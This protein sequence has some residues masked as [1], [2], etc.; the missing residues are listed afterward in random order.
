MYYPIWIELK[1][2]LWKGL[3]K[4]RAKEV[5]AKEEKKVLTQ[6]IDFTKYK[7]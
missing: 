6:V 4:R 3:K 5:P 7:K 1:L 2:H